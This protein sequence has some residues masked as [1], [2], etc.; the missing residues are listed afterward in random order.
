VKAQEAV[1]HIG[2]FV[3]R[4]LERKLESKESD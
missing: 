4:L 2:S 1:E 3:K